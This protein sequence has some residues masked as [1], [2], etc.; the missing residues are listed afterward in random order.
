MADAVSPEDARKLVA[1]NEVFVIDVRE[2]E[3]WLDGSDRIPASTNVPASQLDERLDELP[4]D[5][6]IMVV[7]PD[8]ERSRE[9]AER[10]QQSGRDAVALEGGVEAWTK[11]GHLTQP[12]P[13]PG[14]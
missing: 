2:E 6:R 1:S 12:S 4:Q 8:G 13:D 3:R 7:C 5:Q 11:S 10:L 14:E 9:V